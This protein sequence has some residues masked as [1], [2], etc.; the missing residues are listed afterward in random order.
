MMRVVEGTIPERA[1]AGLK[2][3]WK[4]RGYFLACSC[5]PS[6]DLTVAALGADARTGAIIAGLRRLSHDVL[7][8]DLR[9]DEPFEY[10]AGQYLTL[11]REDGLSRSY[12][13]ANP[14]ADDTLELHVR[15]VPNGLMSG[16]LFEE[17]SVGTR[18]Q[19]MGPSGDCF[20]VPGRE[21]QPIL[22]VGTGTGLAPLYGILRDAVARKHHGPIHLFHGAVRAEGLYLRE[23]LSSLASEN[24]NIAYLPTVL[25]GEA[26]DGLA[27]G[28]VDQ[29]VLTAF[30][31]PA[32]F[33]A[34]LCGD[35]TLVKS[36]KKRLY[37]AGMNMRD[38]YADAF[39]PSAA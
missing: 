14:P 33:R 20:Y 29:A 8:V 4:A 1:Q 26:Q 17:A 6:D 39:L 10:R 11:F 23:E 16:W 38:I 21:E 36:L 18:V 32:G 30:A 2:D 28:A 19:V 12:S 9:C 7:R 24:G 35:P 22:L 34:Y 27:V 5:F 15:R 37:L 31:K 3:S 13:I 25:E